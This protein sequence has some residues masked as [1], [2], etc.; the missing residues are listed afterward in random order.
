MEGAAPAKNITFVLTHPSPS[1]LA[2]LLPSSLAIPVSDNWRRRHLR[3]HSRH[4]TSHRGG[5][6]DSSDLLPLAA[7][8][9]GVRTG[10]GNWRGN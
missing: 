4:A 6:A 10:S 9:Q 8:W 7:A 3:C 2:L 5:S 1:P